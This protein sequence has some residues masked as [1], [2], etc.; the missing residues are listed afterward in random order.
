MHLLLR[1]Q[2]ACHVY[3]DLQIFSKWSSSGKEKHQDLT[4]T[5]A[6]WFGD[7]AV[8]HGST[9]WVEWKDHLPSASAPPVLSKPKRRRWGH[10]PPPVWRQ[11]KSRGEHP[12]FLVSAMALVPVVWGSPYPFPSPSPANQAIFLRHNS[13]HPDLGTSHRN[14]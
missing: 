5:W 13:A 7:F 6:Q 2:R 3:G 8:L 14:R 10:S 12:L 11:M 4:L 9:N 1:T